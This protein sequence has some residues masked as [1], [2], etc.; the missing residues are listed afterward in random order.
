[1]HR[2]STFA[3]GRD[4][5]LG[6]LALLVLML[7]IT[8]PAWAESQFY[9]TY[10]FPLGDGTILPELRIAYETQGQLNPARDNAIVLL[11]DTLAD[12]HAFD[13]LVGPGK[14]FDTTKYFVIAADAIGGGE[15]SS[16]LDGKGQDF[17]RYTIGDMMEAEYAM[18]THGLGLSRVRAVVGRSMGTFVALEWAVKHP[19]MPK[20][21][22]LLGP[23]PK[24]DANFQVVVDLMISAVALDPEW[25]GG[26]YAHNPVEGLRHAGMIYFPWT[27]TADYLN[28]L[29]RVSW[30]GNPKDWRKVSPTGTPTHWCYAMPPAARMTS[31]RRSPRTWT[32]RSRESRCRCCCCPPPAT[33]CWASQAPGGCAP[34]C[35][36]RPMRKSRRSSAIARSWHRPVRPR[37]ISSSTRFAP[38]WPGSNRLGTGRISG[39][40]R[41]V[42]RFNRAAHTSRL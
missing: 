23:T 36:T 14:T 18:I 24:S 17:P 32:R 39:R 28:Q 41:P 42:T 26:H 9:I 33:G 35:R 15:S 30:P 37:A 40:D 22:V 10:D 29:C 20:S 27:V 11:H 19:D 21:L 31:R 8:G 4:G 12:H 7:G 38:F 5:W 2:G 16:P 13:T 25:D 3:T 6:G 34:A 1:M